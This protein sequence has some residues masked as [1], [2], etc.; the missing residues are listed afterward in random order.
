MSSFTL[1]YDFNEYRT[2]V[3]SSSHVGK[4]L[5][6]GCDHFGIPMGSHGL[7]YQNHELDASIPLRY[8]NL[9][10]G[11]RLNIKKLSTKSKSSS[12]D[13]VVR[14]QIIRPDRDDSYTPP[15]SK[16]LVHRFSSADTLADVI[17]TYENVLGLKLSDRTSHYD[18]PNL[19]KRILC[20]YTPR[21]Q[22]ISGVIDSGD[23]QTTKLADLGIMKG[24]HS[25]RLRFTR[26][27]IGSKPLTEEMKREVKPESTEEDTIK[28]VKIDGGKIPEKSHK[29]TSHPVPQSVPTP[30][31]SS[32]P[33][34]P[35]THAKVSTGTNIKVF[36]PTS[37]SHTDNDDSVYDM[38]L[39]QAKAYRALLTNAS[40]KGQM[41][42]R[43]QREKI[44]QDRIPK[45][46][47]CI[48]R[49]RFPDHSTV[50][51]ELE[52]EKTLKDL[53][54]ILVNEVIDE[55]IVASDE[56]PVFFE[57][58]T[59]HPRTVLLSSS[60]DFNKH[61]VSHC[62]LSRRSLL[63]YTEKKPSGRKHYVRQEYLEKAEPLTEMDEIKVENSI[64]KG[65][66]EDTK[67]PNQIARMMRSKGK[68][69][70]PKWF[71]MGRI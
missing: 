54:D 36:K 67:K 39:D 29:A 45:V 21:I 47:S 11:C 66:L 10:K 3:P 22:S 65:E 38:T 30:A 1:V 71:K 69:Q 20:V 13:V 12:S 6:D 18:L 28:K 16:L 25:L 33:S 17:G 43:K 37:L 44:R 50:Q 40:N 61:L 62:G 27:D 34:N 7:F 48:I 19:E 9:P 5:E 51:L 31:T 60:T 8:A 46:S 58:S 53:F 14:L 26:K 23:F 57:L 41:M 42:T 52:A 56:D 4:L 70:I 49:I 15:P 24:N 68:K 35:S 59:L 63:I 32:T 2:K 64:S 55:P